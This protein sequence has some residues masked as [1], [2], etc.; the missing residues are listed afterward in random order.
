VLNTS[1][2]YL[3]PAV[4]LVAQAT[5]KAGHDP[6]AVRVGVVIENDDFSQDVRDGAVEEAKKWGMQVVVD[7]KLPPELNDM[8][9]ALT[10]VR[11]LK[12]DLL[13]VSGHAKGAVLAVRQVAEQRVDVRA[14]ALTQCDSAQIIEKFNKAAEYALC[15]AQWD[16]SLSYSDRW[17]GTAES[18]ALR[19]EKEYRDLATYESAESA[20]AVLT[21]VD[22]IERAG[23]LDRE[24]VRDAIA[25]TDLM[26]FFGPIKFDASGKN[27]AKSMVLY[28]VQ[29]GKYTVV[30]PATKSVPV[31]TVEAPAMPF[32][33]VTEVTVGAE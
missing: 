21:F 10:K 28:Q 6:K 33:G 26:T 4:D 2:N 32:C 3:R 1:D 31:I 16:R 17:F 9:S 13:I 23:S 24:R 20:A 12:P 11:A 7:D 22:A 14:L 5:Q 18:Y 29:N 8:S 27:V 30:A 25:S 19:F 15:A